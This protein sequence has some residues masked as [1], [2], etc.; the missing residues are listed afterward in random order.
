VDKLATHAWRL[1]RLLLAEGA[2]IQK[3]KEF[4]ESDQRNRERE[5]AERITRL[6]DP[7]NNHGLI[8]EI[9]NP[10]VLEFC[11]DLLFQL[12]RHINEH[13]F[14]WEFDERILKKI[15]GDRGEN[16]LRKDLYDSY[17]SWLATS[18]VP[19]EER[20]REGYPSR[21]HCQMNILRLIDEEITRL[22]RDHEARAAVETARTKL[23]IVC[24]NVPDGPGLDRLLRYEASLERSFERTLSQLVGL[25]RMRL[26]QPA[27]P[28]PEVRH[29]LSRG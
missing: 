21:G 11:Q 12:R 9:H 6:S 1:R 22:R 14:K 27:L 23:E 20:V 3:N 16:R 25:Q 8:G 26:G 2:E 29:L 28:K 10:H 4:V 24:R 17:E 15:Y 13:G 7:L 5:E 19:E 18:V